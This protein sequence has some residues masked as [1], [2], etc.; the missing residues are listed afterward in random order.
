MAQTK[1]KK[2][3][4]SKEPVVPAAVELPKLSDVLMDFAAPLLDMIPGDPSG[5]FVQAALGLAMVAW[6]LPLLKEKGNAGQFD[7]LRQDL[8]R[9]L[10]TAPPA[11]GA[12]LERM[13]RE[14]SKKYAADPRLI[15]DFKVKMDGD[16]VLVTA[17]GTILG[18]KG[19]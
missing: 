14:R 11:A 9:T 10:D 18:G 2:S 4:R 13:M 19:S 5:E 1:Q 16:A 12:M 7:E 17:Y 8:Q 3:V 15:T 6:N